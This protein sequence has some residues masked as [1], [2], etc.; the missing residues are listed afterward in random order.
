MT[1]H[2][3]VI[4][5]PGSTERAAVTGELAALLRA[6][7]C[8]VDL[9]H[10]GAEA[11]ELTVPAPGYA[12]VLL[13]SDTPAALSLAAALHARG[14][15][16][17]NT[18]PATLACQDRIAATRIMHDAG[19][20]VPRSWAASRPEELAGLLRDGPLLITAPPRGNGPACGAARIVHTAAQ[21]PPE[22]ADQ[23]LYLV[24]RPHRADGPDRRLYCLGETVFSVL[25]GWPARGYRG[26]PG[27]PLAVS[28][29]MRDLV[30]LAAAAFGL[31]LFGLDVVVRDG[32]PLVVDICSAPGLDGVPDAGLRLADYL[33]HAA[34][35]TAPARGERQRAELAGTRS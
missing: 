10:P 34:G 7:G 25:R 33:Y 6:W 14:I 11:A 32:R 9:L 16:V 5:R 1:M 35:Q 19:L 21:L 8:Q 22:T 24:R 2:L 17:V 30:R 28:P 4:D 23:Q 20:P 27:I 31:E 29:R 3:A 18:Y 15:R 13:W 12:L 26:R